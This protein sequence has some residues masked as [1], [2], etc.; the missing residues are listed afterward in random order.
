MLKRIAVVC[1]VSLFFSSHLSADEDFISHYEYGEMLYKDPRG[2]SC[3]ECHSEDGSGKLI[4]EF[5]DIHG[6]E[7]I[8]GAD[9]RQTSL[10]K[11]IAALNSY[12]KIMP[13]YYLTDDEIKAIYDFLQE[14]TKRL[15]AKKK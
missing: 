7:Q 1:T 15:K 6:K 4:A 5:R 3:V 2:V 10:E 11:M 8:I 9:I 13:R 14:K 12:H